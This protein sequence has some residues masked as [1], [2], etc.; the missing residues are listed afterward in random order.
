MEELRQKGHNSSQNTMCHERGKKYNFRMGG[1]IN[2][3]FE[4]KNIDSCTLAKFTLVKN[5]INKRL[6]TEKL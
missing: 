1:V 2:T 5:L 3:V 4:Y 6:P